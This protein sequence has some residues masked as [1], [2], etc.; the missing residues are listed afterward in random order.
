[1]LEQNDKDEI[2]RMITRRLIL[3]FQKRVGD[4][5]TEAL[6]LT[7]KK[8]VASTASDAASSVFSSIQAG[9]TVTAINVS[10]SASVGGSLSA[11]SILLGG[12]PMPTVFIG[13]IGSVGGAGSPFPSGWT[14]S[15]IATG[16]TRVTHNFSST[17]YVPMAIGEA[18][19]T[20]IAQRNTD[21]FLIVSTND[22]STQATDTG[23]YFIVLK[24]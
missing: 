10:G 21:N 13:A 6:Q 16:Q 14:T 3:G 17:D 18:K 15:L 5:P 8:H 2:Q 23:T 9:I 1:M 4:T 20:H 22:G 19:Q 11:G 12:V 7:N 24:A